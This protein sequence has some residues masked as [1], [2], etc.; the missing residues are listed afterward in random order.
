MRDPHPVAIA[1]S[2]LHLSLLQPVCRADKDWMAVQAH[3]LK[4]VRDIADGLPILCSGDLFDRWNAPPELINF[5]LRNLPDKMLCIP[6]QHDL[7]LHRIDQMERSGYGVLKE[8][9]KIIDISGRA[10]SPAEGFYV[11]GFGWDQ[12]ILPH[13][14]KGPWKHLALC[15]QYIWT[16]GKSYPGAPEEMNIS[17]LKKQL[18]GYDAAIFGDNHQ[19]F[20]SKAGDCVVCNCGGFI[21]RKSDEMEREPMVAII[22]S[23]G[24]IKRKRLDT[25][26][27]V[28]HEAK[29]EGEEVPLNVKQFIAELE[30]LG[31]HGL[32]FREAVE[33]HLRSE[34]IDEDVKEIILRALE[35]K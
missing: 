2:D 16:A 14:G 21:R 20:L 30:A 12:P 9:G 6:G 5:A 34:E 27:D 13:E 23:D 35:P 17:A 25:S 32:N 8:V 3:Y 19:D 10:V 7:P 24:S 29:E 15:H 33:N 18:K 26:I 11:H 28:F 22:Y 1:F 31:E 4:Q